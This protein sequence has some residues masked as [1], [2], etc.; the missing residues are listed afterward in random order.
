MRG[1]LIQKNSFQKREREKK[2]EEIL[3]HL[4][5]NERLLTIK[6]K[7]EPIKQ[8]IKMLETQFS[9]MVNQEVEWKIKLMRLKNFESPNK[10][11]KLLA[12]QLKPHQSQNTINKIR[13]PDM[14]IEVPK[15]IR[16]IFQKLCGEKEDTKKIERCL[17]RYKL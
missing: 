11:D 15:E 7:D 2:K 16:K 6:P 9:M 12:W 5:E 3:T 14:V 4:M 13:E 17:Q 10:T 8:N 1:F